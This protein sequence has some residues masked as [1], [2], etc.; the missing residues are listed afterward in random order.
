MLERRY[1]VTTTPAI[2][3]VHFV[4]AATCQVLPEL[5]M[6]DLGSHA[7]CAPAVA[8]ALQR[9]RPLNACALCC[10][11]CYLGSDDPDAPRAA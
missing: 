2:D 7:T 5:P 11:D 10:S 4:H 9:Y 8:K 3:G 6:E 1:I